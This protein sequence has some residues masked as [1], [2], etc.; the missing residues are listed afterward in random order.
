MKDN[1]PTYDARDAFASTLG[2][3]SP[4]VL[5]PVINPEFM[6]GPP[7]PDLRQA[8]RVIRRP[9]SVIVIS[10]GLSDPFDEEEDLNTGFGL[11]V[12]AETEDPLP[13]QIQDSWLFDL[14]YAVSQQCA[15]HGG[16]AELVE[17]LGTVSLELE[18]TDA[19]SPVATDDDQ[20]GVL[21]GVTADSAPRYFE[22]PAGNVLV[23]TAT[24]LFPSELDYLIEHGKAG[25]AEL[26]K[27]LAKHNYHHKSSLRR[28]P[29]V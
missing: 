3:V 13:D 21:L 11:E 23:L 5:A 15:D 24:L 1:Q 4:D 20:V 27:R 12:I 16:V 7:W 9:G 8:W 28:K 22:V 17:R 6:D 29:L 14:V 10:D 26:A 2:E 19:L 18:A 25:R